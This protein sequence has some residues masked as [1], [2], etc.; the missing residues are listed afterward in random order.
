MAAGNGGGCRGKILSVFRRSRSR[1]LALAGLRDVGSRRQLA[2]TDQRA[3]RC[4]RSSWPRSQLLGMIFVIWSII[5][6]VTSKV[7]VTYPTIVPLSRAARA[8]RSQ[9]AQKVEMIVPTQK[10]SVTHRRHIFNFTKA[11][12]KSLPPHTFTLEIPKIP[13]HILKLVVFKMF[14]CSFQLLLILR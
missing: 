8:I 10:K 2:V 5:R 7:T 1:G 13:F 3:P 4:Q 11:N 6:S 12:T 14:F 9:I